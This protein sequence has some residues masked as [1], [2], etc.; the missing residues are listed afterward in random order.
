MMGPNA[1]TA[2]ARLSGCLSSFGALHR[3]LPG[4]VLQSLDA[5]VAPVVRWQRGVP[6]RLGMIVY[7]SAGGLAVQVR[8]LIN[9]INEASSKI[10]GWDEYSQTGRA[11]QFWDGVL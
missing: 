3:A 1:E 5:S 2:S 7:Y 6:A 8:H 9:A 4:Q 10:P 11:T